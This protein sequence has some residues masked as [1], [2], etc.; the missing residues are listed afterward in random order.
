[1]T[2]LW[3]NESETNRLLAYHVPFYMKEPLFR[4]WSWLN[5]RMV[6]SDTGDPWFES[7]RRQ[8][9][10]EHLLTIDCVENTKNRP[11]MAH[12]SK[13]PLFPNLINCQSYPD[14]LWHARFECYVQSVPCLKGLKLYLGNYCPIDTYHLK[15]CAEGLQ[16]LCKNRQETFIERI[17]SFQSRQVFWAAD[18]KFSGTNRHKNFQKQNFFEKNR[19]ALIGS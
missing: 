17:S 18:T 2:I 8:T 14:I 1:M 10:I 12:F 11:G 6:A 13:E 4:Q 19:S 3:I 7:S 9:F 16:K 15:S 5:G